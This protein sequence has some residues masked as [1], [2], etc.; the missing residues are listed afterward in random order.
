MASKPVTMAS[1]RDKPPPVCQTAHAFYTYITLGLFRCW[2]LP[3]GPPLPPDPQEPW[4]EGVRGSLMSPFSLSAPLLKVESG[5]GSRF[6]R[7]AADKRGCDSKAM[8]NLPCPRPTVGCGVLGANDVAL[9]YF[10][11]LFSSPARQILGKSD[12]VSAATP[13]VM[14]GKASDGRTRIEKKKQ[15]PT[16]TN[17]PVAFPGIPNPKWYSAI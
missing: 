15:H 9:W 3:M 2:E 8:A 12:H 13:A 5:P 11:G 14:K 6:R 7:L 1:K 16:H 10:H 4:M 17:K